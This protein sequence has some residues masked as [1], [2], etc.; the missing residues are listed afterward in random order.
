[1]TGHYVAYLKRFTDV[2]KINH[3]NIQ[4]YSGSI[5]ESKQF[6]STTHALFYISTSRLKFE[7]EKLQDYVLRF[8]LQRIVQDIILGYLQPTSTFI[9]CKSI[10][11]CIS[12]NNKII[13]EEIFLS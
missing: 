6:M 9:S 12:G 3:S 11:L 8:S 5:I 1:M 13:N 7:N 10:D 2:I 4:H